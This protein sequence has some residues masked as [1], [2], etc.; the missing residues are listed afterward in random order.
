[1]LMN[2]FVL[3]V[4]KRQT[5]IRHRLSGLLS[6]FLVGRGRL[7]FEMPLVDCFMLSLWKTYSEAWDILGSFFC[8]T[9][10]LVPLIEL[11]DLPIKTGLFGL[12]IPWAQSL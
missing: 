7:S 2:R 5:Q 6:Q 3:A 12:S 4:G 9:F 1:M 11:F 8:S 10:F